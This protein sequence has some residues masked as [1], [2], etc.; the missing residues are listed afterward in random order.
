MSG[1]RWWATAAWPL[2]L[3]QP[4]GCGGPSA[5]APTASAPAPSPAPVPTP[6]PAPSPTPT[7]ATLYQSPATYSVGIKDGLSVAVSADRTIPIRVRYPSNVRPAPG[8]KLP[9]VIWSHGGNLKADGQ[10][11]NNE[12]GNSLS[13][14]GYVVI[15]MAHI[16]VTTAQGT[17]LYAEFG[18]TGAQGQACFGVAQVLRPR[19][20]QA[21]IAA[22]ATIS[23]QVP[24]LPAPLD[25]D[26][27]AMAGHS[28]GAYTT[29]TIEGARVDLCPDAA[30]VAGFPANW[31][32]RDVSFRSPVPKAFMALSPQGPGRFG[33]FP[34]SWSGLDRPDITMSGD[35][36][37][38]TGGLGGLGADPEEGEQP[39]DRIYAYPVMPA[40]NKWLMYIASP[41]AT[42]NTF[43]LANASQ[44]TFE[45]WVRATGLAFMDTHLRASA[46][47]RTWLATNK[48]GQVSAGVART[49]G[50]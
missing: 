31:P 19:D 44:P 17:A 23:A 43:G 49:E 28:Y 22:L 45:N 4:S 39:A 3:M 8:E 32:Y 20:A 46:S 24:E 40:G 29:R 33:F 18:L 50:R 16:P 10:L 11:N 41:L 5:P 2:L 9:V 21:V 30:T 38:T 48:L 1:R 25:L 12:W 34:T 35:G 36:D 13:A 26:R 6:T 42:H 27:V 15:H 7:P 37:D 47:A 14:A